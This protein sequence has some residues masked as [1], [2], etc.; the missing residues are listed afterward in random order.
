[1]AKK[2]SPTFAKARRGTG[3]AVSPPARNPR[4]EQLPPLPAGSLVMNAATYLPNIHQQ[5]AAAGKLVFHA[6]GDSGGVYGTQAQDAVAGAL[7]A[8]VNAAD[9]TSKPQFL[10]HL[11]D[12][13]YF[14]GE[15]KLYP[16]QFYEP[17]QYY[18]APIFAIPGNHDG[19]THV[20]SGDPPDTDPYSLYG[21]MQNFCNRTGAVTFKHRPPMN[22]PYCYWQLDAPFVRIVGLYS[23]VDG[24]LD[25]GNDTTQT[26]WLQQQVEAAPKNKWLIVAVHHP[27]YS[28]D[29]V[30]GGYSAILKSLDAAFAGAKRFPDLVLSGHVHD[31]QRFSRKQGS[32]SIPY[33]ICGN[34]GY[35]NDEKLLHKLESAV[36]ESQLPFKTADQAGVALEAFDQSNAGFLRLTAGAHDLTMDYFAVPFSGSARVTM[37]ADTVTVHASSAKTA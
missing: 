20:R 31:Y 19:D 3:V 11:G 6:F 21:F 35:A 7:D 16:T 25:E 30:H 36:A 22:Q 4:F 32:A 15:D 18:N 24:T 2:H 10:F 23:N 37:P 13:I 26:D 28:L 8:Q 34:A 29:T 17:Y 5:A 1:M 9:A 33:I 12:V 27:C 14:N